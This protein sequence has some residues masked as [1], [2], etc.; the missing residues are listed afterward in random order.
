MTDDPLIPKGV[1]RGIESIARGNTASKEDIEAV[2][3]DE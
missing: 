3:K 1:L 2:L